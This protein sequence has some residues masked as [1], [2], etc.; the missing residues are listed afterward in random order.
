MCGTD[1]PRK[2]G[3]GVMYREDDSCFPLPF[4]LRLASHMSRP[5]CL[6]RLLIF[7][8]FA[9]ATYAKDQPAQVIVWPDSGAPVLRFTFG[10]FKEVGSIGNERTFMT[11]TTAENLWDKAIPTAAFSLY[12]FDKNKVRIGEG[13]INL[14]SVGV[15]QTVKFQTTIAASGAP[16]SVSLVAKYLPTGL[17]PTPPLRIIAMTVNSVPQG[18]LLKVDGKEVG[19]T[20]KI[21]QLSVGKHQLEFNKEG[22]NAG[23][24][25][26]E[27]SAD[28]A[29]GGSVSYELGAS[30]HDTIE[31][32]DGTVL[33]GDLESVSATE[34]VI[35]A[36]GK[37]LSYARNQVKKIMLIERENIQQAPVMQPAQHP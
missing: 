26:I 16:T 22:F 6:R 9:S 23:K 12:L 2:F 25:P 7:L 34:M 10:K 3:C 33:G 37:D 4:S 5:S 30:A 1:S 8:L 36:G 24:F 15:G 32:R 17:A 19:T 20:P 35:R 11:D 31:L 13:S 27:I 21:A 29:S 28:D 18:A 14:N